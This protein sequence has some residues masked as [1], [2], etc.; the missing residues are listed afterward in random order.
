MTLTDCL[1]GM[2]RIAQWFVWRLEWSASEGKYLKTPCYPDGGVLRMDAGNPVNWMT[3]ADAR[4]AVQRLQQTPELRYTLGFWLTRDCG[5]WFLDIDKGGADGVLT[6]FAERVLSWF[7]GAMVEWSSSRKGVHIF[8]RTA[9]GI[10]DHRSKP[11][12][13]RREEIAPVELEFY[14][15]GRGVAFGLDDAAQ[16]DPDTLHDLNVK[17]LVAY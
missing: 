12:K 16:G 13:E 17:A 10:P 3:H 9:T 7:P 5:Y 6:P 1:G 8:G 2:A 15:E 4:A 11:P 14:T